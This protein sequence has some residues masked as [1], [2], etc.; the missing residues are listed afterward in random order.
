MVSLTVEPSPNENGFLD[1][2]IVCPYRPNSSPS[3]PVVLIGRVKL[4]ASSVLAPLMRSGLVSV[5]AHW[6]ADRFNMRSV[7]IDIDIFAYDIDATEIAT[8]IATSLGAVEGSFSWHAA[9]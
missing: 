4:A 2:I 9:A 1:G 3:D 8:A 7:A 5:R 6:D